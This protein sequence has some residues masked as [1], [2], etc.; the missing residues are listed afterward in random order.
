M[1]DL[2]RGPPVSRA[3]WLDGGETPRTV[4]R[5]APALPC[6]RGCVVVLSDARAPLPVAHPCARLWRWWCFESCALTSSVSCAPLHNDFF[7]FTSATSLIELCGLRC[8]ACHLCRLSTGDLGMRLSH[9]FDH[10]QWK[11]AKWRGRFIHGQSS[12]CVRRYASIDPCLAQ[13]TR[14]VWTNSV[15]PFLRF[16]ILS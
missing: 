15:A 6:V 13:A 7:F 14:V 9:V 4:H 12:N 16:S 11:A 1:L 2:P 5:P 8:F 3:P 10:W